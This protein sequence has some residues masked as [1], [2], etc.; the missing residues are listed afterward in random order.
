MTLRSRT[1]NAAIWQLLAR[2]ADRGLRFLAS[3]VLARVL[4]PDDFGLLA[5]TMM[6]AGIIETLAYLGIDQAVVQSGRSDDPR[7]LGAAFRVMV[8]RGAVLAACTAVLAPVAAWYFADP[9]MTAMVLIVAA[10]PLCAGLENPWMFVERK[11]LRFKPIAI[12]TIAGAGAQVA[13]SVGGAYAGLG[14]KALALG[15]VASAAATTAA[16]WI[17]R[18]KRLDLAR[19]PAAH[20]ELRGFAQRAAGVPFL[21]MLSSSAPSLILGRI[22]GLEV[23]GIFTLAQ[24]LCSLPSE[25]AL[26]LF[27]TVLTP[28]YAGIRG[29]L[30][31]VR[32]VWLRTLAGVS[33]LVMPI[34]SAVVVLDERLPRVLYGEKYAG[35]PGLVSVIAL[36]GL[37][38]SILACSG[39]MLWGLGRPEIDRRTLV[40]RVILIAA[41]APGAAWY[42]GA[43]AFAASLV[44]AMTVGLVYCTH[45]ARRLVS[46]R[47]RDVLRAFV[48]GAL[49]G[50]AVLALSLVTRDALSAR[51]VDEAVQVGAV[52]SLAG[53]AMSIVGLSIRRGSVG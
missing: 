30:D 52:L 6:V 12:A 47:R 7:F 19:D 20:A 45:V 9:A 39:A 14:A 38:S 11:H 23:L 48:P 34:V 32:R 43:V 15:F 8:W 29:D 21:I 41:L 17:L 33:L 46:A 13:V 1:T 24:R 5:A 40:L 16:G 18:A 4:A 3:L 26:P 22:A 35:V 25:I 44:L 2:G 51:G 31:R 49:A 27:G 36:I 28:A 42:G 53:V 10:M 37:A 50:G